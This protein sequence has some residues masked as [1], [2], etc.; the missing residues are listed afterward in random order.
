VQLISDR[1]R[2]WLARFIRRLPIRPVMRRRIKFDEDGLITLQDPVFL[3]SERFVRAYSAG[4]RTGSW[5]GMSIRWRAHIACWAATQALHVRGDFIE[6]GVNRG[7]MSRVVAD[8][9]DFNQTGRTFYLLD[10]FEGLDSDLLSENERAKA[11]KWHYDSCYEAVTAT[12]AD[13]QHARIIKGRVPETLAQVE[14]EAV[15]YLSIDMNCTAPEIAAF[16]HFWPKLSVGG[17]VL[18]DDYGWEGHEEQRAAF[19]GIAEE[20]NVAILCLPT[21]QGLI[22]KL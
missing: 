18:L 1:F 11:D 6:C 17:V 15:A 7:G 14:T 4:A 19:D 22:V 2:G 21:G 3:R 20:L 12:F 10:T 8:F 13:L 9:V 5:G 16:R